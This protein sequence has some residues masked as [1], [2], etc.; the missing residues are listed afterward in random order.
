MNKGFYKFTKIFLRVLTILKIVRIIK[1]SPLM[2]AAKSN[3]K[4]IKSF[5][6]ISDIVETNIVENELV[7][8]T[9][10]LPAPKERKSSYREKSFDNYFSKIMKIKGVQFVSIQCVAH[11]GGANPQSGVWMQALFKAP[12]TIDLNNMINEMMEVSLADTSL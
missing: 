1:E 6:N 2:A 5:N 10:Y 8:F 4:N 9:Y 7:S 3:I 11:N 12:V